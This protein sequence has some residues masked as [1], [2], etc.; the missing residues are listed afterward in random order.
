MAARA[1]TEKG[2]FAEAI[3]ATD[4]AREIFAA[5]SEPIA[6]GTYALAKSGRTAE[7]RAALDEL[8][9]VSAERYVPPYNIALVYNALGETGRAL[10]FLERSFDER[11]ARMV[12]LKVEPKWN[13]LRAEPRFAA[14]IKRMNFE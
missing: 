3:N 6:Y 12:F 7:A 2:M 5:S 1:F 14:L 11:D 9:K 13:N 10:D 4:K 8:L